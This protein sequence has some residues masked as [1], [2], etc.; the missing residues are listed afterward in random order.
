MQA[1]YSTARAHFPLRP[2][3]LAI[4]ALCVAFVLAASP[5]LVDYARSHGEAKH[6]AHAEQIRECIQ[7]N[8]FLQEWFNPLTNRRAR[9]CQLK[10]TLF[11][12]Q[13]VQERGG[14]WQEVTSFLK[15][16]LTRLDQVEQY[17]RNTGYEKIIR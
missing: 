4:I 15:S 7:R 9:V 3:L 5:I 2:F 11:G 12:L 6:G 14:V 16:K 17:L 8:G 13:I 10:E 1:T